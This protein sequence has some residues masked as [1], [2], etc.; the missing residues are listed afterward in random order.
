[1]LGTFDKENGL[2]GQISC[3]VITCSAGEQLC[4]RLPEHGI[5]QS[6]DEDSQTR[7]KMGQISYPQVNLENNGQAVNK[8]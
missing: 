7:V 3:R 2:T 1:M 8:V 6:V 4:G 5:S